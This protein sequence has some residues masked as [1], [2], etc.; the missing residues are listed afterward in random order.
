MKKNMYM[1]KKK[2]KSNITKLTDVTKVF[3]F[4]HNFFL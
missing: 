3:C 1:K 4:S 2:D